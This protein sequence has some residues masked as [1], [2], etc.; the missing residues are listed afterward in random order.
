M[1]KLARVNDSVTSG[2][3]AV[4]TLAM[5]SATILSPL[6]VIYATLPQHMW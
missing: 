3:K 5:M 2:I 1:I 6:A 4:L